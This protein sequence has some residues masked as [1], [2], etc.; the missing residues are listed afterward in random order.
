MTVLLDI[1]N[2]SLVSTSGQEVLKNVSLT[3][4]REQIVALIG[5]SGS[6]K[7]TLG[8]SALGLLRPGI[9][10]VS[11]EVLYQGQDL[12]TMGLGRLAQLRGKTLAYIA[13]SAA[14]SFNPRIPL[15]T[16]VTESSRIHRT[17]S[18]DK[19]TVRARDVF[20]ALDLPKD[21]AFFTR[22]PHQV[23]G[24]QLQRFMIAMGLQEM[25]EV[26]V[27]D[28]P[29]SALDATTQVEVLK[30][31]KTG[32]NVSKTAA[33]LV[34]H[35]IAQVVQIATHILVMQNGEV[36]E[37]G[38]VSD[39]LNNAQHPYTRQL[40]GMH[41]SLDAA[42]TQ[43]IA[44]LSTETP[45]LQVRDIGVA[46]GSGSSTIS[47]LQDV[48]L[49]LRRRE[50]MAIVGESGSGKS[51]LARAIAG[52]VK[53]SQGE[54]LLNG[55]RLHS[56]VLKRPLDLRRSVQI[57]FQS[58]DTSLNRHHTVG[59]ILG[60]VLKFYGESSRIRRVERIRELLEYVHLPPEYANRKPSQMSGGEKQRVNLARSLAAEPDVL[61]CD[62]I[63][64]ALDNIVADSV[65]KL[66]DELKNRL[67]IAVLFISHD[68]SA[69]AAM[70]DKIMVLRNGRVVEQGTTRDVLF[71]PQHPYTQ[72]LRASVS[73]M[74]VGWLEEAAA[75]HQALRAQLGV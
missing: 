62:E 28:E 54:V 40:V 18:V 7:T 25:P 32:I 23:S 16:Q 49:D 30:A 3:L 61:I 41:R 58:A 24:G 21:E 37:R 15:L 17:M 68:L 14:M 51:T 34:A 70:A 75:H 8:L 53:A 38:S 56:D 69:V 43:P 12:V 5:A 27:C 57:T 45:L 33:I 52:L 13:Q 9:Q 63:T 36:V 72:L 11:G 47:A 64:S 35:D 2:L 26:L 66:I 19:A 39:I 46:Y 10:H 4:E 48:S 74:R 50:M 65:L 29:T 22:Y 71:T 31:L 60:R 1:R 55:E 67:N 20:A 73:E 6:G 59:K 42:K 44:P